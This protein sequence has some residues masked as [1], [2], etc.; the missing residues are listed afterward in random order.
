[1]TVFQARVPAVKIATLATL[2][3]AADRKGRD[4]MG[5]EKTFRQENRAQAGPD[6]YAVHTLNAYAEIAI[7]GVTYRVRSVFAGKAQMGE[8]LDLAA[9]EKISRIA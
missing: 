9:M 2:P 6:G 5:N 1:M 4:G 3:S 7:G 8:L